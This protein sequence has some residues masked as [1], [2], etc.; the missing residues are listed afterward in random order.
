MLLHFQKQFGVNF[1]SY[2]TELRI[3]AAVSDLTNTDK[4]IEAIAVDSG[5]PNS[6]AFTSAFKKEYGMLPSAYRRKLKNAEASA[7][8]T[9]IVYN[10]YMSSLRKYLNRSEKTYEASVPPLTVS[11]DFSAYK[12]TREL[13]HSWKRI[14]SIGQASDILLGDIQRIL[15]RMQRDIGFEYLFFNGIFSDSLHVFKMG[16]KNTPIYN[17]AYTDRIFDFLISIGLKP[18]MQFSYMPKDL[19]KRSDRYMLNH[20]VSE[21]K[22]INVWCDLIHNF[23]EH[24]IKR[25][26]IHEILTWKFSVWHQPNTPSRLFGFESFKEFEFFYKK[27]YDT[28]KFFNKDICF[29]LPCIYYLPEDSD[30]SLLKGL[31]NYCFENNCIP[32]FINYSFYDTSLNK[33]RNSSK[34]S[35]GFMES[36]TLNTASDGLKHA[37]SHMKNIRQEFHLSRIPLYICSI[38]TNSFLCSRSISGIPIKKSSVNCIINILQKMI[39]FLFY[40]KISRR[41]RASGSS[42]QE[43]TVILHIW[44]HLST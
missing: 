34:D 40:K 30:N 3:K 1:L 27:T 32:D 36:M 25:Y 37:I 26:G 38:I 44:R 10:E 16:P 9:P 12:N 19:A 5:F 42:F 8:A 15:T 4:T 2:L 31:L 14:L 7:P 20:L 23:L 39:S 24:L 41:K 28:V 43:C 29:G 6:N 17:F 18:L 11:A 33:E 22:D 13:Q 21:P 35:F